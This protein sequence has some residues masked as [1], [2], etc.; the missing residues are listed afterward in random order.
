MKKRNTISFK[1]FLS[2]TLFLLIPLL[3]LSTFLCST[4]LQYAK[5]EI[6]RISIN[7]L[8]NTQLSIQ[9]FIDSV[10]EDAI[11]LTTDQVIQNSAD[12]KKRS[13][14]YNSYYKMNHLID[15]QNKMRGMVSS[16]NEIESICL[17]SENADYLLT[18]NW[19]IL[20][21]EE[22]D[23]SEKE[24]LHKSLHDA[25]PYASFVSSQKLFSDI[26]PH[27]NPIITYIVP[28]PL[29][30]QTKG[31]ILVNLKTNTFSEISRLNFYKE[32]DDQPIIINHRGDIISSLNSELVNKLD[33]EIIHTIL[34]KKEIEGY[35]QTNIDGKWMM[36]AYYCPQES[37]WFYI[38]LISIEN[39]TSKVWI[40]LLNTILI[41][42]FI[43][44]LG[45][46]GSSLISKNLS[47][48]INKLVEEI[49]K[50]K[51]INI[52]EQGDIAFL[53]HSFR[54]VLEQLRSKEKIE[55]KSQWLK[56]WVLK[57]NKPSN[58]ML[59]FFPNPLYICVICR[60]DHLRRFLEKYQEEQAELMMDMIIN[61]MEKSVGENFPCS[62]ALL[63]SQNIV[64]IVNFP[65]KAINSV[66]SIL[67]NMFEKVQLE[68]LRIC[69]FT[70]SFGI[71]GN[72]T[73]EEVQASFWEAQG[74][75]QYR[76]IKGRGSITFYSESM[77]NPQHYDI[78]K[79]QEK[80]II[81]QIQSASA[82][83][84]ENAIHLFFDA[85]KDQK[86][87]LQIIFKL[88]L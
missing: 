41:S 44:V 2:L 81:N 26:M 74:A 6:A 15:A 20:E 85:L 34:E 52:Y 73:I 31:V 24:T 29:Y 68:Y 75:L 53:S 76:M 79:S 36:A 54:S 61:M 50:T 4:I 13:D 9:V 10:K 47:D 42:V 64:L 1:I 70:L 65:S 63:E 16:S 56:N 5:E 39:L 87:F 30:N 82:Q 62:C 32:E 14:A 83:S 18:T 22:L 51:S 23:T 11:K 60:I 19:G 88:L 78:L 59:N 55:S 57:G 77:K 66:C 25:Y 84:T 67:E 69:D 7:K 72:H 8:R 58:E 35:I 48:P 3:I 37:E 71:G 40:T 33:P 45:L 43:G 80:E 27:T 12:I 17:Y 46:V 38:S 28:L 49:K 86:I 21:M